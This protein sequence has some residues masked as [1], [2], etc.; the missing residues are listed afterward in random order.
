MHGMI[1]SELRGYAEGKLGPGAWNNVLKR[2]RLRQSVYLPV[3]E[4][5]DGDASALVT[6]LSAVTQRSLSLILEDVGEFLVPALMKSHGQLVLPGW[7][8]ID[9]IEHTQEQFTR[10]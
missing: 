4:Y 2:A 3:Q 1:F 9:I 10:L 5:P 7:K 6:A 8:T